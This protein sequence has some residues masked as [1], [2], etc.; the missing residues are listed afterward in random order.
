MCAWS[1]DL[2]SEAADDA[3]DFFG[4]FEKKIERG[5]IHVTDER[6]EKFP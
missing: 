2:Y 1:P 5:P 3:R 6:V 4:R